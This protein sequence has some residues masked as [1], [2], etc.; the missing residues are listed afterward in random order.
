MKVNL[1]GILSLSKIEPDIVSEFIPKLKEATLYATKLSPMQL[2]SLLSNLNKTEHDLKSLDLGGSNF[3]SISSQMIFNSIKNIQMVNLYYTKLSASQ[4]IDI[5]QNII[6][7]DSMI[8]LK[9]LDIGGNSSN[10]PED[11]VEKA[12]HKLTCFKIHS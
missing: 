2:I 4:M 3:S 7:S 8:K 6:E 11:I 10:I 1:S 12:Q 5:L 9:D